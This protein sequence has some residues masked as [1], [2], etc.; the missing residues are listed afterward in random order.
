M[1]IN[2]R[3]SFGSQGKIRNDAIVSPAFIS[4]QEIVQGCCGS[5][6]TRKERK[7]R[8][9]SPPFRQTDDTVTVQTKVILRPWPISRSRG[10]YQ[11]FM[12]NI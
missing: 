7:V 2:I 11:A 8:M 10:C 5:G 1:E 4:C 3:K 12:A 9:K 6:E